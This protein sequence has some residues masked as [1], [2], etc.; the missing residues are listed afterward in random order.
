VLYGDMMAAGMDEM[1]LRVFE[2]AK[3]TYH[4]L[5]AKEIEAKLSEEKP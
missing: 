3:S 5:A 1:A 4:P 2:E